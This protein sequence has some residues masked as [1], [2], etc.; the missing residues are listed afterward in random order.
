MVR[1]YIFI[2]FLLYVVLMSHLIVLLSTLVRD[3]NAEGVQRIYPDVYTPKV[4][5]MLWSML[6][7]EQTWFGNEEWKSY[8]IQLLPVTVASEA[9]DDVG[10]V[11]EMVCSKNLGAVVFFSYITCLTTCV[12][13]AATG[14]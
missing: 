7:Q 1:C 12:L 3:V 9:R 6:A 14:V 8:G 2:V 10:W 5:G 4:V 13:P 11:K